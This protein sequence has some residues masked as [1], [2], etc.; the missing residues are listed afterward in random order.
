VVV[1]IH[2]VDGRAIGVLDIDS[3]KKDQFDEIDGEGYELVVKVLEERWNKG[4][5]DA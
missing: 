2:D 3:H 5:S 4:P 1:P